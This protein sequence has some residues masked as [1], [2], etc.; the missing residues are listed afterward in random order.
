MKQLTP[1]QRDAARAALAQAENDREEILL[2]HIA[3]LAGYQFLFCFCG[4]LLLLAFVYFFIQCKKENF[5]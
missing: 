3:G 2:A 1:A 4:T 5:Q